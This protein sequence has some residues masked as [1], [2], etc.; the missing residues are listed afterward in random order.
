[1]PAGLSSYPVQAE[2]YTT[3]ALNKSKIKKSLFSDE[4][5]DSAGKPAA[6]VVEKLVQPAGARQPKYL[7]F[8]VKLSILLTDEQLEMV[9]KVVKD[10]MKNRN[11][12]KERITKNTVFRCLVD[13]LAVMPLDTKD[14]PDED[15]LRRRMLAAIGM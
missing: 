10:I 12:K 8:D 13:L 2:E 3:M 1:V 7:S 6:P 11:A 5:P 15:E 14:I 9:E 4:K